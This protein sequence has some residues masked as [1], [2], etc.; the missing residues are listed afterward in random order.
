VTLPAGYSTRVVRY[1]DDI[2]LISGFL[3]ECDLTDVGFVDPVRDWV[4]EDLRA[5]RWD[6]EHDRKLVLTSDGFLAG[7]G[8]CTWDPGSWVGAF[9]RVHPEHRGRGIGS[10]FLDWAEVRA[11]DHV[12]A[13]ADPQLQV[14]FPAPDLA[15]RDLVKARG[16]T[17]VRTSWDME[18]SLT[19]VEPAPPV[20]AGIEFRVMRDPE[21]LEAVHACVSEGFSEHF[22]Y[23]QQ[24]FEEWRDEWLGSPAYDQDLMLL[25]WEGDTLVGAALSLELEGVAWIGDLV[26]LKSWRG[27]GIG[28]ALLRQTFAMFAQRGRT[29]I[30]LGV[31]AGNETGATRLYERAGMHVRREWHVYRKPLAPRLSSQ[32]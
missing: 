15:A 14:F 21:D 17:K 5:P 7:F 25:A 29:E 27:R 8:N 20:P 12:A 19:D 2:D 13:G 22:G 16:F 24:E 3:Q 6:R 32:A 28:E 4:R 30:R 18:R 31:D 23:W 26:V 10:W 11:A 9:I 1:P